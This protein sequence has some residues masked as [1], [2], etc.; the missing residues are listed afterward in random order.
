MFILYTHSHTHS[1]VWSTQGNV[2]KRYRVE[3]PIVDACWGRYAAPRPVRALFVLQARLLTVFTAAGEEFSIPFP[4][5][6]Q[7]A[8]QASA[9]PQ[10]AYG[11]VLPLTAGVLLVP[12]ADAEA[13]PSL[14]LHPLEAPLPLEAVQR[15]HEAAPEAPHA[16]AFVDLTQERVIWTSPALPLVLTWRAET[17]AVSLYK[18]QARGSVLGG[19]KGG[20]A[21]TPPGP[22]RPPALQMPTIEGGRA[23][24]GGA[25]AGA[26]EAGPSAFVVAAGRTPTKKAPGGMGE[27]A[28]LPSYFLFCYERYLSPC[29][30]PKTKL[31]L[32]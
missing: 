17:A 29:P 6:A 28:F 12:R 16:L 21:A 22:A 24:G 25:A 3:S 15:S 4:A 27:G 14:L 9:D 23:A 2:I 18:L 5:A 13:P 31:P 30:A 11:R 10:G 1:L 20:A 7:A 32:S 19:D 8:V 26:P